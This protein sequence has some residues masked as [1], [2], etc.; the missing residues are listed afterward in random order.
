[1]RMILHICS[2]YCILKQKKYKKENTG[3]KN[4]LRAAILLLLVMSM[5]LTVAC[6]KDPPPANDNSGEIATSED[7]KVLPFPKTNYKSELSIYYI[8]WGLYQ[9]FF[10]EMEENQY[11][12][13]ALRSD[14]CM[15]CW[16]EERVVKLIYL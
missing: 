9:N 8:D 15:D 16:P 3:M 5:L 7:G 1:M 2:I 13:C 10:F 11:L 14:Q 4:I 6:K 12:L